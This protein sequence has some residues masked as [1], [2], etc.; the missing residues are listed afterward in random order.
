MAGNSHNKAKSRAAGLVLRGLC[1]GTADVIPGVS[2]G[3]IALITGI[4][5][6]L[7]G[8]LAAVNARLVTHLFNGRFRELWDSVNGGFLVPLLAGI[9]VAIVSL[10][11]LITYLLATYPIPVWGFLTGLIAASAFVVGRRVGSWQLS[12]FILVFAGI[13]SGY[14]ISTAV[15]LQTGDEYYKYLL[16]GSVGSIA[17]ILPG[18]SGSFIL[19]LI[20]KYEQVLTAVHERNLTIILVFGAGFAVG[21]LLFSRLLKRLLARFH[22]QTMAFLLGLMAGSLRRVWPFRE[23]AAVEGASGTDAYYCVLPAEMSGEVVVTFLLMAAGAGLVVGLDA[24]GHRRGDAGE[25]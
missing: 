22:G 12:A 10:A 14:I 15:P 6:E 17:M 23:S 5:D 16:A 13:A 19:V 20:G 7:V 1:M 9:G 8:T 25:A 2:G 11:R 18:I 24:F 4:Y 3:T 21:I